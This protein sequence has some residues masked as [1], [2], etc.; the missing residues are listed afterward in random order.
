MPNIPQMLLEHEMVVYDFINREFVHRKPNTI[1]LAKHKDINA[2]TSFIQLDTHRWEITT[3][4][5]EYGSV[6]RTAI[7]KIAGDVLHEW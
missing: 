1:D 4:H 6:V 5:D 3:E 7:S 2:A